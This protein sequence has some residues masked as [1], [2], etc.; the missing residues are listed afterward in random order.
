MNLDKL[1]AVCRTLCVMGNI[2]CRVE[3]VPDLP[4]RVN[5]RIDWQKEPFMLLYN[6]SDTMTRYELKTNLEAHRRFAHLLELAETRRY[7]QFEG[8]GIVTDFVLNWNAAFRR[9]YI[10]CVQT[11]AGLI[12]LACIRFYL[13]GKPKCKT[14]CKLLDIKIR[15]SLR[16][17][18]Q[19]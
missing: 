19:G 10:E 5:L 13:N 14:V 7:S 17:G 11:D 9:E 15:R 18:A 2:D 4:G 3:E 8:Y 1:D 16:E 6:D 12:D